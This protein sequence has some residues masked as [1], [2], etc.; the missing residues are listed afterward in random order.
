MLNEGEWN[1]QLIRSQFGA[2]TAEAI[3]Q[4]SIM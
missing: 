1:E 3:L 2:N 4:T